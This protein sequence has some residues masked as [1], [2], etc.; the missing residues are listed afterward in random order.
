MI[1]LYHFVTKKGGGG[2]RHIEQIDK[3]SHKP[4]GKKN[5]RRNVECQNI[6]LKT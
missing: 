3:R 4:K 2:G 6:T 5:R 1:Q